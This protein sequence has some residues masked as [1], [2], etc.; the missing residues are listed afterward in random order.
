MSDDQQPNPQEDQS[1]SARQRKA[2][3][4]DR[5]LRDRRLPHGAF[6]VFH[7]LWQYADAA[8]VC[9]PGRRTMKK[10]IG[11]DF[12]SLQNWI[13]K[14]RETGWLRTEDY[15]PEKHTFVRERDRSMRDG[16]IYY[17]LNGDKANPQLFGKVGTPDTFAVRESRNGK[18]GKVGTP[19]VRQSRNKMDPTDPTPLNIVKMPEPGLL[20][21]LTASM[22]SMQRIARAIAAN[23]HDWFWDNCKVR[24]DDLSAASLHKILQ[25][26]A[27]QLQE[28]EIHECWKEA[29]TRAHQAVVDQLVHNNTAGYAVACFKEQL[30]KKVEAISTGL[31]QRC[32]QNK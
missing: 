27:G 4:F 17:L 23:Q 19:S 7:F 16:M 21:K 18:S 24:P 32:V 20:T 5:L 14:L 12:T 11:G 10:T 30:Q 31:Y 13:E 1:A 6:R 28:G 22:A 25:N 2:Q 3:A 15:S 8:G 9:W 26:Y 29:V